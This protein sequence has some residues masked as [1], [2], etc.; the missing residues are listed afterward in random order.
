MLQCEYQGWLSMDIFKIGK[1]KI[2]STTK[3]K[4]CGA[5]NKT[6]RK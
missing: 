3:S 1:T 2:V 6:S 5:E 4:K